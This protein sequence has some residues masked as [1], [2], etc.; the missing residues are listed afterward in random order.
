MDGGGGRKRRF[1]LWRFLIAA[2]LF[3]WIPGMTGPVRVWGIQEID[4]ASPETLFVIHRTEGLIRL[5]GAPAI[6][7]QGVRLGDGR[8][9]EWELVVGGKVGAELQPGFDDKVGSLGEPM[10]HLK[11]A[12]RRGDWEDGHEAAGKLAGLVPAESVEQA[13]VELARYRVATAAGSTGEAV[14]AWLRLAGHPEGAAAVEFAGPPAR[15]AAE[16]LVT[17][18]AA[19]LPPVFV[20]PAMA[21]ECLAEWQRLPAGADGVRPAGWFVYGAALALAADDLDLAGKTFAA[22]DATE[23]MES[24]WKEVSLYGAGIVQD[25]MLVEPGQIERIAADAM[26]VESGLAATADWWLAVGK[27]RQFRELA[28][29]RAMREMLEVAARRDSTSPAVSKAALMVAL[30]LAD[31]MGWDSDANLIRAAMDRAAARTRQQETLIEAWLP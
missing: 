31:E 28:P 21:R 23:A 8:L 25:Q 27:Q 15:V 22:W 24:R 4:V 18:V 11:A 26:L 19:D 17:G 2:C 29:R 5:E 3:A 14:L 6:E 9:V 13:L 10:W 20:D 12:A 7:K 30:R 1:G 16:W